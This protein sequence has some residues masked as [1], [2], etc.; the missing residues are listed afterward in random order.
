MENEIKRLKAKC[1]ELPM[2]SASDQS[3]APAP[4]HSIVQQVSVPLH[5][6]GTSD[7]SYAIATLHERNARTA[8]ALA[9]ANEKLHAYGGFY[10][11]RGDAI[12]KA[13]YLASVT[14]HPNSHG[15]PAYSPYGSRMSSHSTSVMVTNNFSS[16]SRPLNADEA[17]GMMLSTPPRGLAT[18]RS[19]GYMRQPTSP[20]TSSSIPPAVSDYS[21]VTVALPASNLSR[22]SDTLLSM[23]MPL[24]I[25]DVKGVLLY[26]PA[27]R[28]ASQSATPF[29]SAS[30][31]SPFAHRSGG[32]S[33][34][35]SM[36]HIL[37][38]ERQETN[39]WRSFGGQ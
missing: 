23:S 21:A 34:L 9:R 33:R 12:H 35:D 24:T 13:R 15:G 32:K 26:S 25:D 5:E 2:S 31:G 29:S 16:P 17:L 19:P 10:D 38:L 3:V 27:N 8:D 18:N 20:S 28:P 39:R 36:Y 37:D 7:A 4:T 11:R 30:I 1:G 6:V 22:P 14:R